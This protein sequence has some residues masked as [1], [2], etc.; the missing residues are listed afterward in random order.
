L[1]EVPHLRFA[2]GS[3]ESWL[4]LCPAFDDLCRRGFAT[5]S[6]SCLALER[7]FAGKPAG[8]L[9][10]ANTMEDLAFSDLPAPVCCT[11]GPL[12]DLLLDRLQSGTQS[13]KEALSHW[14][15]PRHAAHFQETV[16]KGQIQLWIRLANG[17][18][19][20]RAC[21]GLLASSCNSV[22]VHDLV[23]PRPT[24]TN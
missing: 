15:V 19:E 20:R 13:F 3:F 2:A 18:D 10:E 5:E 12:R 6:F 11:A 9:P 1:N 4:Q 14:M 7:V 22:G 17:E 23:A 21:Q 16:E 8:V 24:L